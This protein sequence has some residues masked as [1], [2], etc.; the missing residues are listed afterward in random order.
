MWFLT[1][2]IHFPAPPSARLWSSWSPRS[3]LAQGHLPQ[4]L[5]LSLGLTLKCLPLAPVVQ[6]CNIALIDPLFDHLKQSLSPALSLSL[7]LSLILSPNWL[8]LS[9]YISDVVPTSPSES[10]PPQISPP[11]SKVLLCSSCWLRTDSVAQVGL[12]LASDSASHKDGLGPR[13]FFFFF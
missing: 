12:E 4:H 8:F 9:I 10:T 7:S 2:P 6:G 3:V 13:I 11:L 1:K 5:P